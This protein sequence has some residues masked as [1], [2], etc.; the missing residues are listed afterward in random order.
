[1]LR[2]ALAFNIVVMKALAKEAEQLLHAPMQLAKVF[3]AST[4][5][6][7]AT[8]QARALVE[9]TGVEPPLGVTQQS[10][11][12]CENSA[13]NRLARVPKR[14]SPKKAPDQYN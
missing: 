10:W 4:Q 7:Q 12:L 3:T 11:K 1:L 14:G 9:S 13:R 2:N 5:L 8:Q 6:M